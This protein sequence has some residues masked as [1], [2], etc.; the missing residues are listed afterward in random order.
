MEISLSKIIKATPEDAFKA[1]TDYEN[2]PCWSK[3]LKEVKV[4][5]RMDNT[6]KLEWEGEFF[7]KRFKATETDILEPPTKV[8]EEWTSE[9]GTIH[10]STINF[11]EIPEGTRVDWFM[12]YRPSALAEKVLGFLFKSL[13]RNSCVEDLECFA[14]YVEQ[15][16]GS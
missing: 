7:N 12:D 11:V 4:V 14:K 3:T 1:W 13:V 6:L 16:P 10:K 8:T 15:R 2:M 9:D 5:S